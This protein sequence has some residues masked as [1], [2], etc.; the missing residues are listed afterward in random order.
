M[1]AILLWDQLHAVKETFTSLAIKSLSLEPDKKIIVSASRSVIKINGPSLRDETLVWDGRATCAFEK[2]NV[3]YIG[4]LLG[5]F[6][7]DSNRKIS[8]LGDS[9]AIFKSRINAIGKSSD[10]ALWI[11]TNGS[12]L[13]QYK[14]NKII[15]TITEA[16]G[17]TSNI[18]RNIFIAKNIIWVGT[19]KGLNKISY[20]DG[21]KN[22][23]S[24]TSSDGLNS[25]IINAVYAS[26]DDMYVGTPEG[27]TYFNNTQVS[28]KSICNLRLTSIN[29][30]GFSLPTDTSSFISQHNNNNIEFQYVGIS[31]KSGGKI[32][33]Q[34]RLIGLDT[35]WQSSNKTSLN[36]TLPSGKYE[37]QLKAINK[38]GVKSDLIKVQFEIAKTI[39]EKNWFK[40]F[41]I[42]AMA[43]FLWLAINYRIRA[44][45]KKEAENS[46]SVRRIAELEQMALKSQMNPH[47]IFNCLNS[48]QHYVIDKDIVGANEFISNFSRLIRLT[49]DNSSK[50]DISIA[51]EISY[52]SAYLQLEQKRF[53]DKFDFEIISDPEV[54]N[55]YFIPSMILQPYVENAIRH[56]IRYRDDKKGKIIIKFEK[57]GEYMICTVSDNGIGRKLSFQLKSKNPI[58]YQS[59]GM[60]LT[61]SR[62]DMFNKIHPSKIIIQIHDLE[63]EQN[64]PLGTEVAIY[65]P[66]VEIQKDK[67][68]T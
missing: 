30:S 55:D 37:L 35:N 45:R 60:Q 61:A 16:N 2:N 13:V 9:N 49:L 1:K 19:D 31:Y 38:F 66:L 20:S 39:W 10:G 25:D 62:I 43:T 14:N 53:E 47:F 12:G 28:K 51:D 54:N 36:Y 58:E 15:S 42:I 3:Y 11:A 50:T 27:L 24:F 67:S 8:Y 5:L 59:K 52:I 18:C 65:F 4:T 6:T 33:Y 23:I 63:D 26:G 64:N 22:I 29:V 21:I 40:A 68:R 56:G 41:I 32:T 17:L 34:Y 44:I 48:I 57:N 7:V 46:E